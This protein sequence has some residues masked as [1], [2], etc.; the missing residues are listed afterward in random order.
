MPKIAWLA[1]RAAGSHPRK[2]ALPGT[3]SFRRSNAKSESKS[4]ISSA[5]PLLKRVGL[6]GAKLL[7]TVVA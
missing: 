5:A 1:T 4:A 2:K 7:Q 6:C 3:T